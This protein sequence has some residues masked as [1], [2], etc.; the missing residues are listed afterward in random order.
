MIRLRQIDIGVD[1]AE[2]NAEI[3]KQCAKKLRIRENQ[4]QGCK[5][6]KKSIDARDKSK[7]VYCYEIDVEFRNIEDEENILKKNKSKDIFKTEKEEYHFKI[8]G[9]EPIKNRPIIVGA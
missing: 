8:T 4:I 2:E 9:K 5:I 3:L 7:I 1:I 6:I